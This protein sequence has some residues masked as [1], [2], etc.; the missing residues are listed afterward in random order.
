VPTEAD[1]KTYNEDE[2]A[3]KKEEFEQNLFKK[4]LKERKL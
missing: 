4:V 1:K 3:L 2:L